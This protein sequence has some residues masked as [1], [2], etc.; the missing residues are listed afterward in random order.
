MGGGGQAAS[1][2]DDG[3]GNAGAGPREPRRL[4]DRGS[5]A[6]GRGPRAFAA[7]AV[8]LLLGFAGAPPKGAEALGGGGWT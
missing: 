8:L 5:M 7:L 1:P 3:G 6:R 2:T 4:P